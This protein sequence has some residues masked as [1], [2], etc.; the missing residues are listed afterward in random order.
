MASTEIITDP[1]TAKPLVRKQDVAALSRL[2]SEPSEV[3]ERRLAGW[4]QYQVTPLPDPVRHLW[5]YTDPAKLLPPA[6]FQLPE[7]GGMSAPSPAPEGS[8]VAVLRP[9]WPP[10]I[11]LSEAAAATGLRLTS[12]G[13]SAELGEWLGAMVAPDHGLFEALNSALWTAGLVIFVPRGVVAAEPV[14]VLV[15]AGGPSALPRILVVAQQDSELTLVEDHFGGDA[16]GKVVGVT[17]IHAGAGARIRHGLIE[18]WGPKTNGHLTTRMHLERDAQG[19]LMVS[20]LG[21]GQVKLDV[22]AELLGEGS[23]SEL[24]AIAL[25]AGRQHLDLHTVHRHR[26]PHTSSNMN[27]KVALRDRAHSATTGLI[28]IEEDAPGSEAYQEARN[29]LLSPRCRADAIPELQIHNREVQCTHGATSSPVDPEQL[30]YLQSRGI[31]RTE[32]LQLVV[33]GFFEGAL[34]GLPSGLRDATVDHLDE[35]LAN[36]GG[37]PRAGA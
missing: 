30:Y 1:T 6:P 25:G 18:R 7:P 17:E 11:R 29:L 4:R 16:G 9:G 22:G 24:G 20:A 14:R 27:I 32:A 12:L 13:S 26:A 33:R 36:W 23:H 5:R 2:L 21:G 28:E 37:S 3:A 35:R 8:A 15:P 34:T 31:P 19:A 10:Q